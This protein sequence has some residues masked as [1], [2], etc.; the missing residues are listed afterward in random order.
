VVPAS[1]SSA[2]VVALD[3][4]GSLVSD[5]GETPVARGEILAVPAGFGD[6]SARGSVRLVVARP[7]VDWPDDLAS[8]RWSGR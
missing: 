6:W 8:F 1:P 5:A 2:A 4:Q 3:G 7:G